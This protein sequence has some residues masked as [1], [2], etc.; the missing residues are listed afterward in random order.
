MA[1]STA[2]RSRQPHSALDS[3]DA[4]SLRAA[5][6]AAWAKRNVRLVIGVAAVA[7]VLVTALVLWRMNQSATSAEAAARLLALR[8]NPATATAAGTSELQ[9]FVQE[10]GGTREAE[11]ARLMLAE[12]RLRAGEPAQ[13]AAALEPLAGS[14]SPLA[15]QAAMMMGSAHAE[16]GD[17][18]AAVAAFERAAEAFE[19]RYQKF[20]ALGQA[21]LMHEQAGDYPA[22]VAVYERMLAD[23]DEDSM[24]QSVLQMRLTEAR[25]LAGVPAS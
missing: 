18:E 11:E 15:A 3:E 14:G 24:Q 1:T 9:A 21:A 2:A 13:A 5:E 17:R 10:Y 8:Q 6:L 7:L 25:A 23:A 4:L 20:E 22:A 12:A 16:A 19:A